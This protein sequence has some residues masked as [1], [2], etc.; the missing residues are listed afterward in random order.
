MFFGKHRD[1]VN[2]TQS[3]ASGQQQQAASGAKKENSAKPIK[4]QDFEMEL[5]LSLEDAYHGCTRKIEISV[6]SQ[7]L[8]R[9][10]VSIPAGVRTGTKIKV[11][12]EGRPGQSGGA[13]GDLYLKVKLRD[14]DKF[15]LDN[16]DVHSELKIE[17]YE[18]VL[19]ANK[20]I[21][22]I[23]DVVELVIPPN[24]HA[25]RILRLR[26]KGLRNSKG[27]VLGDH[28]VHVVIDVPDSL[29]NEELMSY[30][31]LKELAERK[32]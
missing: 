9:L 4:G 16:D 27:E 10:E 11:A 32:K 20:R 12:N 5:E 30:R 8:R 26:S 6:P 29:T 1:R 22:T 15:W 21:Q 13:P 23:A 31:Y 19:G 28:Y 24:T 18:A 25:G 7:G 17:A 14:H 2:G 3:Q